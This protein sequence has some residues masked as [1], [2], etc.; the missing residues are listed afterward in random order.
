MTP[1][2]PSASANLSLATS[3][4]RVAL[5][6]TWSGA[7]QRTVRLFNDSPQVAFVEF[8]DAAVTA[9]T[10]TSMA[11]APGAVEL[12][13]P[14]DSRTHVAGILGSG[15]GTLRITAGEGE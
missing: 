4:D 2:R 6:G 15:S 11:L 5:P 7:Q 13:Y 8:G 9:S 1:F 12:F 3:S 14:L 10:T